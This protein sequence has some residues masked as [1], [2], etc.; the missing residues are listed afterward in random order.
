MANEELYQKYIQ[1]SNRITDLTAEKK[2]LAE[3]VVNKF[4]E[5][6]VDKI[7]GEGGLITL[8][9]RN[10]WIYSS[11]VEDKVTALKKLKTAEEN[12]G[13]A[14]QETTEFLRVTLK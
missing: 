5:E 9:K 11:K 12:N 7:V 3:Q 1:I 14:D 8:A 2:I 13:T 10:K 4:H 6:K